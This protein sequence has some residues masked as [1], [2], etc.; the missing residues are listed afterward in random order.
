M[1]PSLLNYK[2]PFQENDENDLVELVV[3]ELGKLLESSPK[4]HNLFT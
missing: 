2:L 1:S 4:Y 3:Y